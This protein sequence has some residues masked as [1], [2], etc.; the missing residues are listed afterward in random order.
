MRHRLSREKW[1]H[2]IIIIISED[3]L[4]EDRLK[5]GEV[6]LHFGHYNIL[7]AIIKQ[8]GLKACNVHKIYPKLM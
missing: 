5:S 2:F 8:S 4:Y 3:L 1:C 6:V 7:M